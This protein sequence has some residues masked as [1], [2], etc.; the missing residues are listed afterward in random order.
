[1][2]DKTTK[3][4]V[5]TCCHRRRGRKFF[6]VLT[7]HKTKEIYLQGMCKDCQRAYYKGRYSILNQLD[8]VHST[9]GRIYKLRGGY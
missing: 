3:N 5:C 6:Y 2:K 7:H 8:E 1:M 4:K 9:I